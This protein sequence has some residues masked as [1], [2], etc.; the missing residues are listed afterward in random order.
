ML[1]LTLKKWTSSPSH[2]PLNPKMSPPVSGYYDGTALSTDPGSKFAQ[3][4]HK[5]V[6]T[7][8]T[9]LDLDGDDCKKACHENSECDGVRW[10]DTDDKSQYKCNLLQ[11]PPGGFA[12]SPGGGG[13]LDWK[14]ED[15]R[16]PPKPPSS[17]SGSHFSTTMW[18]VF[19]VAGVLAIVAVGVFIKR[20]NTKTAAKPENIWDINNMIEMR[21][22]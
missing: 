21:E 9:W 13:G 16:P 11:A 3:N 19:G 5:V 10:V 18:I 14:F 1:P 4:I 15:L 20:G 8:P 7:T 2:L 22:M 12:P 17:G 6:H